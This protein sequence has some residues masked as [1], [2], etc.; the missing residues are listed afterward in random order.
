MPDERSTRCFHRHI[1]GSTECVAFCHDGGRV[2][3]GDN[4]KVW[5]WN[6]L[7]GEIHSE[8]D[9][10]SERRHWVHS[11]AFLHDGNH[12]I[13]GSSSR[14]WIW[15]VTIN[16]ST[17]LSERIQLPDGTRV[18]SLSKGNF[19]IYDPVDQETTNGIPPYLLSISP[20]RDWITGEQTEHNCW[21]PPQYQSFLK[22]HVA[23]SIACLQ[24]KSSMIVL[25][26]K[27]IRRAERIMSGV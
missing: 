27:N 2:A 24:S 1:T 19:H 10:V 8:P 7:T 6:L 16:E 25:D 17:K 21:I 15:N 4:G 13:S 11:I 9:R 18:H 14:V 26:L 20:D 3:I 12:V 5:I 23:K 22:V